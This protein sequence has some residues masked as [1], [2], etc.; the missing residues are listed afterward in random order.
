MKGE[1]TRAGRL[2]AASLGEGDRAVGRWVARAMADPVA[3]VGPGVAVVVTAG[4]GWR[5]LGAGAGDEAAALG[6]ATRVR[7]TGGL[8]PAAAGAVLR[9]HLS[10]DGV[11]GD[12]A[13]TLAA[14]VEEAARRC[15]GLSLGE[16]ATVARRARALLRTPHQP[17]PTTISSIH[18]ALATALAETQVQRLA[19]G[20]GLPPLARVDPPVAWDDVGGLRAAKQAVREMV[21][22]PMRHARA[23]ARLGVAPPTGLLLYGPPGTGKT[24]VAKA[25]ACQV[26][27]WVGMGTGA[28]AYPLKSPTHTH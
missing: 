10:V 6:G 2:L 27:G 26:S 25:A 16:V 5:P 24:L 9:A 8:G 28:A 14:A 20:A 22:W 1:G 4:E 3:A 17:N 7:L 21:A 18:T 11:G 13:A 19:S 23:F 12:P 15:Q